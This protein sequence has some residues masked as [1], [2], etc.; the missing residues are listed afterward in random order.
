MND[1]TQALLPLLVIAGLAAMAVLL[2]TRFG[3]REEADAIRQHASR[4]GRRFISPDEGGPSVRFD[5][6]E[7]EGE[8]RFR[9][10]K[11]R[12]RL[13]KH[14]RVRIPLEVPDDVRLRIVPPMGGG[15]R[16]HRFTVYPASVHS[17]SLLEKDQY[18]VHAT[19]DA[20]LTAALA[21][22]TAAFLARHHPGVWLEI[23]NGRVEVR[24]AGEVNEP[25]VG[26][27]IDLAIGVH[28]RVRGITNNIA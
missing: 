16:G 10:G 11:R 27:A 17:H 2:R 21:D 18:D 28:T 8:A 22:G 26:R 4:H 12:F 1:A 24:L 5:A 20:L 15:G 3:G 23:K 7:H 9:S 13:G 14:V 19:S 25:L 6:G